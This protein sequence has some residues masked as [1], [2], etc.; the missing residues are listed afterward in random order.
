MSRKF[1]KHSQLSALL[2]C[3]CLLIASIGCNPGN[4][5]GPAESPA[6]NDGPNF[7]R[8]LSSS[9]AS[10]SRTPVKGKIIVANEGGYLTNGT[11]SLEIPPGALEED[12]YIE[13]MWVEDGTL[14]VELLPHGIQFRKDVLLTMDLTGTT[15]EDEGDKAGVLYDPRDGSYE[16]VKPGPVET[17]KVN[18]YLE[19]FSNYRGK[20]NG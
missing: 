17:N 16:S 12:T 8:V 11:F 5:A 7:I 13:M 1:K 4:V 14:S 6:G 2:A 20:V 18:A 10:F 3:S 9:G 19:H 15:A